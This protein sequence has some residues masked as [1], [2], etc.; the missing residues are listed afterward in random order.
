MSE[1]VQTFRIITDDQSLSDNEIKKYLQWGKGNLEQALNYYF[2]KKEKTQAQ[3][4]TQNTTPP[5]KQEERKPTE[6]AN[7][8]EKMKT[9][10]LRQKQTEN[11]INQIRK[12][13]ELPITKAS[14]RTSKS[15]DKNKNDGEMKEEEYDPEFAEADYLPEV[16]A[17]AK[18]TSLKR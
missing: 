2:R 11:F 17:L 10:S 5:A 8:F 9:A 4:P 13:Y 7:L 16:F 1:Q 12:Q 6:K 14:K 15:Q 3:T 18:E